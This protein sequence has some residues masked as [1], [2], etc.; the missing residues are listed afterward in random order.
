M[1][2]SQSFLDLTE[3][4]LKQACKKASDVIKVGF[5]SNDRIPS[6][7]RSGGH[8]AIPHPQAGN[9]DDFAV[10]A[11][12]IPAYIPDVVGEPMEWWQIDHS[13]WIVPR[14][15]VNFHLML[16]GADWWAELIIPEIKNPDLI[17]DKEG[18]AWVF[19]EMPHIPTNAA[20]LKSFLI[21]GWL[22]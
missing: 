18:Y 13:C 1:E 4:A 11:K 6:H 16:V 7:P 3:V 10:L 21:E 17:Y 15:S 22:N 5:G 20:P 12:E 8:T 2:H 14:G 19:Y 9:W